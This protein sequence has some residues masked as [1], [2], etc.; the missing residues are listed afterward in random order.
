MEK[1]YKKNLKKILHRL[2]CEKFLRN[3]SRQLFSNFSW[4]SSEIPYETFPIFFQNV[5][6][7][8]LQDFLRNFI[9]RFLLKNDIVILP[10]IPS[11]ALQRNSSRGFFKNF[12]R[13]SPRHFLNKSWAK[14]YI[15]NEI[16]SKDACRK[17]S[18]DFIRKLSI[19]LGIPNPE[20][21]FQRV[22]PAISLK[23]VYKFLQKYHQV[24]ENIPWIKNLSRDAYRKPFRDPFR[25]FCLDQIFLHKFL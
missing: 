23:L 13:D 19:F 1:L 6:W 4:D 22:F 2:I 10:R 7:E 9:K 18:V 24:S 16:Y 12:T 8:F 20:K 5:I 15:N 3:C 11:K 25:K 21:F 14:P 17:Y